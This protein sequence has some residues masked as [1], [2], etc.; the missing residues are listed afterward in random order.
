MGMKR[1][2]SGVLVVCLMPW[3]TGCEGLT[4]TLWGGGF[5]DD[6]HQPAPEP[7]LKLTQTTD[8]TDILVQYNE[9]RS[10]DK[11]MEHRA[12]LLYEN[13]KILAT[14]KKPDFIS[15]KQAGKLQPVP[16]AISYMTNL[17]TV[18]DFNLRVVLQEDKRHFTLVSD[19]LEIGTY[20]LPDYMQ[21]SGWVMVVLTPAA[22]TGD[23][24]FIAAIFLGVEI[25][26]G[27]GHNN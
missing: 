18:G 23:V 16:L 22:V 10:K 14:R 12:Y 19:G 21:P 25:L 6:H 27:L 17:S 15:V 3:M 2:I 4:N 13:K 5:G 9:V 20:Q 11:K 26:R 8:G 7:D 24:V 1:W